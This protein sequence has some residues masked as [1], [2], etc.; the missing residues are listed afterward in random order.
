MQGSLSL[1]IF[2]FFYIVLINPHFLVLE[3]LELF[4]IEDRSIFEYIFF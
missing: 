1:G 2:E 3:L 4:P